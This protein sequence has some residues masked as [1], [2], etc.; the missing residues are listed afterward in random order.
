MLYY[1][2]QGVLHHRVTLN[3]T[4]LCTAC[5]LQL[6]VTILS[7]FEFLFLLLL[8]GMSI[9]KQL[10]S[11]QVLTMPIKFISWLKGNMRNG[12]LAPH[13]SSSL[14]DFEVSPAAF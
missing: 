7:T 2:T 11:N 6:Y 10:G 4:V 8:V 14:C 3:T 12:H 1:V 5:D 13:C 9:L